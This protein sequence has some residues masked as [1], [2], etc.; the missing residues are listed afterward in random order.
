MPLFL[1]VLCFSIFF[2]GVPRAGASS[3]TW[4]EVRSAHFRVITDV[5]EKRG[6]EVAR[7]CEQMRAAFSILMP[8]ANVDD[9][10]PL[11]IFAL[12]G[13]Q[14]VDQLTTTQKRAARHA[15]V[16]IPGS[17]ENLIVLDATGNP[18]HTLFHEYAHELLHSNSSNAQT[19]FEE[20][21]A[22]YFSTLRPE[23]KTVEVGRVPLGE[24][25]F[26]RGGGRLLRLSE[27]AEVNQDS[28][29]YN[30]NGP[31]Q[32]TFYAQS[33]LLVHYLFDH[34]L[35]GHSRDLFSM[36]GEG[37]P[38]EDALP[39]AFGVTQR[40]LEDA[41]LSYAQGQQ[42][43]FFSLPWSPTRADSTEVKVLSEV[44]AAALTLEARQHCMQESSAGDVASLMAEYHGLLARDPGNPEVLRG[45]GILSMATGSYRESL[46]YL[47]EAVEKDGANPLNH[48]ALSRLLN[49]MEMRDMEFAQGKAM[50]EHEAQ[51]ALALD[52]QYA[53]A[54]F[55]LS[56][57]EERQGKLED[58]IDLVRRA[59]ALSP[60][61]E[62][63][64]LALADIE[65][66]RHEYPRAMALLQQLAK[67][68][69]SDIAQKAESFLST[70]TQQSASGNK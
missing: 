18:W 7:H 69:D 57:A 45:M 13:E 40:Q 1:W 12:R 11:L 67:S 56:S 49:L 2:I 34:G 25:E 16:F 33:W 24:L 61:V 23:E 42:F 47:Q 60:R 66:K 8:K 58:A 29:I 9:P 38:L 32:A 51:A 39:R 22:D 55:L 62:A 5:G 63:Y 26:L 15:G 19:W 14:E 6:I 28:Q 4:V 41:L 35:I 3:H 21:F 30:Q 20:G 48:H 64:K 50:A 46:D 70:N 10:A 27:L 44:T 68:R 17:D 53:D 31:M 65:I 43:R 59:S 54:F 37:L 36:T 52:P